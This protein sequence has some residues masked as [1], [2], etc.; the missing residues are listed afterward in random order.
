MKFL[1]P[2]ICAAEISDHILLSL[3]SGLQDDSHQMWLTDPVHAVI[4]MAILEI[5]E[6]M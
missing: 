2:G 5:L 6:M 3:I 1:N 4:R